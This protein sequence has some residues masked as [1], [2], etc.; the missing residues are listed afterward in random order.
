M[1]FCK[2]I[3]RQFFPAILLLLC[4]LMSAHGHEMRPAIADIKLSPTD[5]SITIKFNAELFLA[6]I[7]A[8]QIEDS[9][10][11]PTAA[12]YDRMRQLP[13]AEL[14]D[15]FTQ[16]WPAFA[17]RLNGQAGGDRLQFE[18]V[19]F[20]SEEDVDFSLPRISTAVIRAPMPANE[21]EVRFGWDA[22]LGNLILR[23]MAAASAGPSIDP[24]SLY[25][26]LLSGGSL[27]PALTSVGVATVPIASVISNYIKIGFIHIIPRGLDHILFVLG[28]FLYA[29]RWRPLLAQI[30]IFTIAHSLT[31]ALASRGLV[32]VPATIVEPMIAASIAYVALENLWQRKLRLSR[33]L[34]I[35]TFGLLHGLGFASVLADIGLPS[36]DFLISLISFNIGVELG[37]I[38]VIAAALSLSLL[39]PLSPYRY[40]RLITIPFSLVIGAIGIGIAA[41]RVIGIWLT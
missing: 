2:A 19:N 8:S 9:D 40:R 27:S 33:L 28:L 17:D 23:Q 22:R 32:S 15:R 36:S 1:P 4:S 5:V 34:I 12:T 39:L 41:E 20:I 3:Y 6:D 31:L 38:T 24:D 11:A 21:T 7:D 25:T 14:R 16:R 30:T 37:Q 29:P 35:F 26:G 18:L 10:D 13:P